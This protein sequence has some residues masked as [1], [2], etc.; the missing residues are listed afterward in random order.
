MLELKLRYFDFNGGRGEVARLAMAIGGVP[1]E[2]DRIPLATWPSVREQTPFHA[3]PVLEVDG[4]VITQSNAINRYVGRLA[5]LYPED[6]LEAARCDEV[7]DAVEDVATQ[8]VQTFRIEDDEEKRTVREALAEGPIKL[9]LTRLDEMLVRR[10]GSYFADNRLTVA[11][12]KV[13]VWI[14]NL[15]S[16]VLDHIPTELASRVAPHLVEQYEG[17]RQLP[18]IAE[19]YDRH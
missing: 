9:F 3:V 10:G 19:Y 1:F 16:G 13:F 14:G 4:E 11:D 5:N 8:I 15:R 7:L 12:L 2:D 6:S 18:A 17:L